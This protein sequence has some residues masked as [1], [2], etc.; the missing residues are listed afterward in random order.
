VT[1][2]AA[3]EVGRISYFDQATGAVPG[4]VLRVSAKARVFYVT[5]RRHGAFTWYKVGEADRISLTQAR[6]KAKQALALVALGR[7]PK[8][9]DDQK[10]R[11]AEE[12][13]AAGTFVALCRDWLAVRE[14]NLRQKTLAYYRWLVEQ[15]VA[16]SPLGRMTAAEVT[17]ADLE[18]R[19]SEVRVKSG[20]V[21]SNRLHQVLTTACRWARKKGKLDI[22]PMEAVDRPTTET[23][24]ERVL[25]D[26]EVACLWAA[27]EPEEPVVAATVKALLLLGQR[28]TATIDGLRWAAVDLEGDIPKWTI[29]GQF[30]KGGRLHVVPLPPQ[31]VSVIEAL[32]PITGAERVL[33]GVVASNNRWWSPIRDRAIALAAERGVTMEHFTRHDLRRTCMTGMTRLGVTR[34]VAQRVIGH[35]EQG[36]GGTYDRYGYLREKAAALKTWALHVERVVTGE[37]KSADVLPLRRA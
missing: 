6:T 35:A 19:L 21:T 23:T 14:P 28:A 29:A 1:T 34:F 13:R 25:T 9:E 36:V 8:A 26:P 2:L 20:G 30:Q 24:R 22:N 33:D 27:L 15:K 32:R 7:D 5:Y 11:E 12:A 10:R 3:P 18:R 17:P 16:D 31:M 4:F 37:S